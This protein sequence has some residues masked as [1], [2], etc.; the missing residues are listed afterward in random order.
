VFFTAS[1]ET[2][3]VQSDFFVFVEIHGCLEAH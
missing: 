2:W 3:Q 1:S